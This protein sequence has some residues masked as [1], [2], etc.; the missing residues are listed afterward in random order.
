MAPYTP[1]NTHYSQMDVSAYSEEEMFKF[2]GR[3][4]KRF[5]GSRD[6]SNFRTSGTIRNGRLSNYGDHLVLFK[7]SKHTMLLVVN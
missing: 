6:F 4:G 1:P 5:I 7:I 2:V 3:N